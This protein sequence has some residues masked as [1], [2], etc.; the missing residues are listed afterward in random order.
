MFKLA[1]AVLSRDEASSKL[2]ILPSLSG[3]SS[4]CLIGSSW[5]TTS[6]LITRAYKRVHSGHCNTGCFRKNNARRPSTNVIVQ[7]YSREPGY[8]DNLYNMLS[9]KLVVKQ[10]SISQWEGHED[11]SLFQ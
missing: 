1:S 11:V 8:Y 6:D 5:T 3:T 4:R 7:I 2:T 9:A 10:K